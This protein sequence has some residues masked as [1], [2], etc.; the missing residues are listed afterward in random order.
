M[1][2]TSIKTLDDKDLEFDRVPIA[3]DNLSGS[4]LQNCC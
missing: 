1:K 2:Q 3:E 4:H